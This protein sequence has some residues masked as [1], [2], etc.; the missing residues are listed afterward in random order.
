MGVCVLTTSE[1]TD[2]CLVTALRYEQLFRFRVPVFVGCGSNS[3]DALH[4]DL[5]TI[6][7]ITNTFRK[8]CSCYDGCGEGYK[9]NKTEFN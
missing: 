7:V 6:G 5:L 9:E 8:W 4:S 3:G 1:L 2:A